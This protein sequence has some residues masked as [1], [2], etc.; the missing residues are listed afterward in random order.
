MEANG[1]LMVHAP[2]GIDT[3]AFFRP[4]QVDLIKRQIAKGA[5]AD[6]FQLFLY[7]CARTGL[8]P[9]SKQIYAIVRDTWDSELKRKVPKMSI[10]TG[11]DGLRLIADRTG[12]Y[13]PGPDNDYVYD[14]GGNLRKATAHVRKRTVDGTWH[15]ISVSAF[16]SEYA[17]YYSGKLSQMWDEKPHVMLGKCA[18]ALALRKAFPAEMSGI[19]TADEMGV[20]TE[21]APPEYTPPPQE[22][23]PA[24]AV[25]P[26][27]AAPEAAAPASD[28]GEAPGTSALDELAELVFDQ[29]KFTKPYFRNWCKK[30]FADVPDAWTAQQMADAFSLLTAFR[31]DGTDK[32]KPKYRAK[33]AEL[34]AANRIFAGPEDAA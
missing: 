9:F 30:Y 3:A 22:T 32:A 17:Q 24:L 19:Y 31:L 5:T 13:A 33:L 26:P 14:D 34:F 20:Q 29:L 11:I 15:T 25:V 16:F 6:E 8:D 18:E 12:R 1:A 2:A 28:T 4:E 7:Q 10:Q 27:A 21:Q 23:K